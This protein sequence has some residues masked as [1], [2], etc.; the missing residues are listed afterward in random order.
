MSSPTDNPRQELVFEV[1]AALRGLHQAVDTL[2]QAVADRL[3]VNLTDLRCIQLL[4]LQGPLTA[5]QLAEATK[6][7]TGAVTS[8]IDRLERTGFA[9]RL[10]DEAD[11]RRVFVALTPPAGRQMAA[12]YRDLIAASAALMEGYSDESL[13]MIR[14]FIRRGREITLAHAERVGDSPIE[15]DRGARRTAPS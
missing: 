10:R 6:L 4:G 15:P 8:V 14:D 13:T 9:C 5:G 12:I 1:Q 3:G 7:T 11:R 2:N